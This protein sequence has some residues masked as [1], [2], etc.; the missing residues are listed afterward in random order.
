MV[1]LQLRTTTLIAIHS[2]VQYDNVIDEHP[3]RTGIVSVLTIWA[4]LVLLVV[5]PAKVNPEYYGPAGMSFQ[6][7]WVSAN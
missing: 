1:W 3:H 4:G 6:T 7:P 2:I 5:I